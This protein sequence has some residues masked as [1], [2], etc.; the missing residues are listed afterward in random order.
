MLISLVSSYG[1][2]NQKKIDEIVAETTHNR[3][4]VEKTLRSLIDLRIVRSIN[5]HFEIVHDFLAKAVI[6]DLVSTDERE[7]KKFKELLASRTAAYPKTKAI[8]TRAEH[9]YI[10]RYRNKILCTEDEARLLLASYLGGN[11]PVH[12]WLKSY[13]KEKVAT[14]A[15]GLI[16]DNDD[17][18]NRNVYRFLIE[19]DEEI[20]LEEI[21][22]L[23]SDYKLKSELGE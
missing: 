23:Y 6:T 8:L 22:E 2:K 21:I 5:D 7:A 9:I 12:Y 19:Q 18:I 3:A 17:E 15:R 13:P 16:S 4:D 14:W 20:N 1:T 10:Y 11:G